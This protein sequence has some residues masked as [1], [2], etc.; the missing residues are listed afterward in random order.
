MSRTSSKARNREGAILGVVLV[1]LVILSLLGLG[2][3]R[4]GTAAGV[5]AGKAAAMTRAFWAAEAGVEHARS[6][7]QK[8]RRPFTQISVG[9]SYLWGSNV[10]NGTVGSATYTVDIVD[11]PAWTNAVHALKK[12]LI[13]SRGTVAGV[14]QTVTVRAQIKSIANYMQASNY[15]RTEG[16]TRIYFQPGDVIDG[17]VYVNDQL[18]VN[19]QGSP[20]PR[21]LREA[22]SAASS[23]NYING[24]GP[25]VFEDTLTLDAP[26][27][28]ISGQ[29]TSEHISEVRN[30]AQSGG[31]SLHGANAGNYQMNFNSDGS[32]SY[33]RIGS[34]GTPTTVFLSSLN[35]AI[36]VDG[37]AWVNG[38]VKGNVTL[39][40]Q[41]A[42]YITNRIVYASA[43]NPSPWSA[44]FVTNNVTDTLGLMASNQV[45]IAGTNEV[46]IH[47]AVMVT[48]GDDGFNASNRYVAIGSPYINLYG[49]LSQYRRGIVSRTGTPFQG[50]RKNWKFDTR[51]DAD[52]PPHFP[53]SIYVFSDWRQGGG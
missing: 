38:T 16:G 28:D 25:S 45:Q 7:G 29:F 22:N 31:L 52:A 47:A 53:Y 46:T 9:G 4:L 26:P 12:Y 43:T 13:R 34:T 3:I 44:G 39:A 33:R 5:E 32:L 48:S 11:D 37:D 24:A 40:A 27:L 21:F 10:L 8:R 51:F 18:N 36:Y 20:D 17:P 23:V 2:L 49:S 6:I 41:D 50:Y 15:E 35:G 1:V 19:G 14:T 42:I 30:T